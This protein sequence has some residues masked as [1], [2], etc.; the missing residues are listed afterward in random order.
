[1]AEEQQPVP[2][3]PEHVVARILRDNGYEPER[4]DVDGLTVSLVSICPG[5]KIK[6][7]T[8]VDYEWVVHTIDQFAKM[9]TQAY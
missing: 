4:Y 1:M 7:L 8:E 9:P 2:V 6:N 3:K 5:N